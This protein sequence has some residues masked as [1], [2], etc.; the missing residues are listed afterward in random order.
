VYGT[1][2][3]RSIISD[4]FDRFQV[5][6]NLQCSAVL[7]SAS[8]KNIPVVL[9]KRGGTGNFCGSLT[10]FSNPDSVLIIDYS[11]VSNI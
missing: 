9:G 2:C 1:T 7:C 10:G 4:K 11:S 8:G 5:L 6:M 3:R